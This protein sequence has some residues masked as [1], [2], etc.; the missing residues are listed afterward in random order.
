MNK[1]SLITGASSGVGLAISEALAKEEYNLVLAARSEEKLKE[2]AQEYRNKYHIQVLPVKTNLT[3]HD[4]I[5][6]L[7]DRQDGEF[8][9][10]GPQEFDIP[11]A[12]ELGA[13]PQYRVVPIRCKG[14][15]LDLLLNF[16]PRWHFNDGIGVRGVK[17]LL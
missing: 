12:R 10:W 6:N 17:I 4:D 9:Y 8:K 16:R 15:S 1:V 5:K 2:Q 13:N 11:L 3:N 7:I 14:D